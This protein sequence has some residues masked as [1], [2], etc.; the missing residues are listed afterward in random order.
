M[1]SGV[2]AVFTCT[3]DLKAGRHWYYYKVARSEEIIFDIDTEHPNMMRNDMRMNNVRVRACDRENGEAEEREWEE[4]ERVLLNS[5]LNLV[6]QVEETKVK[7]VVNTEPESKTSLSKE[8]AE[9]DKE[10]QDRL[11][12]RRLRKENKKEAEVS[13]RKERL[14]QNELDTRMSNRRSV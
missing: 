6:P 12:K 10:I 13:E 14:M 1:E 8:D 11:E 9:L 2:I 7:E 4:K 5:V 3:L